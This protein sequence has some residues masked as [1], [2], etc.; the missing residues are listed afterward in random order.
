MGLRRE[1]GALEREVLAC[2]AAHDRPMSAAEVQAELP[3]DL[4]YTTVMTTLSR[5]FDKRALDRTTQGRG[6]A[7]ALPRDTDT[8]QAS[9]AAYQMQRVLDGGTDRATVLAQFVAQLDSED[10]KVLQELLRRTGRSR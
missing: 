10:E 2:L 8:A 5:L 4:A 9:I 3:G 6:Y 1:R 7:Y